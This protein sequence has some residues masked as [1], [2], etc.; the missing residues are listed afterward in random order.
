[1]AYLAGTFVT[2]LATG[3][4]EDLTDTIYNISPTETPFLSMI[5]GREKVSATFHEWQTDSLASADGANAV[6]EGNDAT[7]AT[8]AATT[9]VG[10]RTQI[11]SKTVLVSGTQEVVDK[12]GRDSEIAYQLAK[13][14]A[15]LKRDMETILCANQGSSAGSVNG[16]RLLGGLESW[17]STNTQGGTNYVAGG[18][19]NGATTAATDTSAGGLI[20]FTENRLRTA[21]QQAWTAGGE[22]DIVLVGPYA[23][24]EAS[25]FTGIATLYRD[26]AGSMKP[27]SILG[28]ADIYVSDFGTVKIVPSRF[29]RARTVHV[30]DSKMWAVGYLRPFKQQP[31]AKTGDGEKRLL[32]VEYTL[33]SRNQAASAVIA[34]VINS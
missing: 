8:A 29:S 19:A 3:N 9:R 20:S 14:S 2:H 12:A 18:F 7:F 32:N 5:A 13:R 23:K 11:S 22:P 21:M 24:R 4:R 16:A 30:L 1:M 31:L 26:T 25:R 10:N 6:P 28:A 33:V 17:Y 27:A 15:E 34:D